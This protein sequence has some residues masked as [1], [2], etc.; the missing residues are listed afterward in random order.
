MNLTDYCRERNPRNLGDFNLK[1]VP[2]LDNF[3]GEK[4]RF[5]CLLRS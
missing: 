3:Q 1:K 4:A 2:K 5:G